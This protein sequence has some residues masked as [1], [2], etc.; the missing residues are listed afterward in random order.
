[1]ARGIKAGFWC[2]HAPSADCQAEFHKENKKTA[3][4]ALIKKKLRLEAGNKGGKKHLFSGV[5]CLCI[6]R[7]MKSRIPCIS[8]YQ[9]QST[10]KIQ[11]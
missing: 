4:S 9:E 7:K 3:K 5:C 2:I 8:T 11:S 6:Q 10:K 1:V